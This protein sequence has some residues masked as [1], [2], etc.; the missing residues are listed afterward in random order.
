MTSR[1]PRIAVQSALTGH[2]VLSSLHATDAASALHRFLDMGIEPFLIASSVLGVVGQR[3][4]RRICRECRVQ[5]EPTADEL[6]FYDERSA[7]RRRTRFFHGEGCNFCAHTGYQERI[8]VYEV[9]RMTDAMRQLVVEQP[10]TR[11]CAKLAISRGHALAARRGAAARRR[12]HHHRSPRSCGAST[13]CRAGTPQ[14]KVSHG[15]VQVRRRHRL[16]GS[17][18]DGPSRPTTS[19]DAR[20][21]ARGPGPVRASRSQEAPGFIKM[22]LITKKVAARA[23]S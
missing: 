2:F 15:E 9:L 19:N 17:R 18:S 21:A 6:A 22:E 13:R 1:P 20:A 11:T 4:V 23:R 8:G 12:R 16:T 3:L 10:P 14:E 7:A 5:Y